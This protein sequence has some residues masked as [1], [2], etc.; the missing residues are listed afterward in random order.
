MADNDVLRI[1]TRG[2]PL[3]L[4]QTN[5]VIEHLKAANPH[6]KEPG[7]LE[8]VVIKTT[9]DRVQNVLLAQLGGKGLF[10]KELDEAMLEKR[11]DIAIHSMKDVPTFLPVGITLHAIMPR[12][13]VRDAFISTHAADI[14]ALRSGARVGTASTR[15]KAQLLK[16]RPDLEVV[17][18][19]GNVDTRLKKLADGEV[20]A[21]FLA[22]AGLNRLG[23]A[24]DITSFVAPSDMLPAVGQGALAATCRDGDKR[25]Q[26][27]LS[28]LTHWPTAVAVSAERAMLAV[29]DGSCQ[30]PIAGYGETDGDGTLRLRGLIARPDGTETAE[31]ER[32]GPEAEADNIGRRLAEELLLNAGPGM[33]EAIKSENPNIIRVPNETE[34]EA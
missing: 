17:P 2:S 6:L 27:Y 28:A 29:L 15:R 18:F 11:I 7:N 34:G 24:A 32:T 8:M 4:T 25:S 22:A 30:T 12:E 33:I 1:G 26:V 3:A 20:E 31:A 5:H 19:R 16:L 13:D 9:G 21:T 10:T 23:R 14:G